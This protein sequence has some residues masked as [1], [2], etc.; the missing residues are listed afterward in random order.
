MNEG[1]GVAPGNNEL[2][3]TT[4]KLQL[5]LWP[6]S[7]N[8]QTITRLEFPKELRHFQNGWNFTSTK[9]ITAIF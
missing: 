4:E 5:R 8:F 3:K 1:G 2:D 9:F 6:E 7:W